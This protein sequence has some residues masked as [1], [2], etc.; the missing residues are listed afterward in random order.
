MARGDELADRAAGV[1]ADQ[2]HVL[3]LERGDEVGDQRRQPVGGEV[4]VLA[5]RRA[6]RAERQVGDDAAKRV[7]EPRDD[8]APERAVDEGAMDEDDR[9]AVGGTGL[10]IGDRAG[11][12]LDSCAHPR[13]SKGLARIEGR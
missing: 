5:H 2:G 10:G 12:E 7:L 11:R 8:L 9:R 4:G 3:E 1:V 6:V 13:H